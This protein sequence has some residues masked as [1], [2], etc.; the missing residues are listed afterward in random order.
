MVEIKIRDRELNKEF[1]EI[2]KNTIGK[3]YP[4]YN[5]DKVYLGKIGIRELR[6]KRISNKKEFIKE[7]FFKRGLLIG[8]SRYYTS[9][10]NEHH[11]NASILI[12]YNYFSSFLTLKLYNFNFDNELSKEDKKK[13]INNIFSY[14]KNSYNSYCEEKLKERKDRSD[15][16]YEIFKEVLLK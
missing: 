10:W 2:Y 4:V 11:I 15:K 5:N 12:T 8:D 16:E 13:V 3:M 6:T 9:T 1:L 7:S 14:I